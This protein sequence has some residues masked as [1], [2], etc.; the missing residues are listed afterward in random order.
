MRTKISEDKKRKKISISIDPRIYNLWVEYCNK[1]DIENYSDYIEK[2]IN[3]N[4]EKY[5]V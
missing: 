4:M 5:A 1:N 3:K 2:L